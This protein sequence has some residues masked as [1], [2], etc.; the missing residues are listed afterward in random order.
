MMDQ[1]FPELKD[2]NYQEEFLSDWWS[3][4]KLFKGKRQCGKS[5]LIISEL[6]RFEKHSFSAVVIAPTMDQARRL[7]DR[8]HERFGSHARADFLSFHTAVDGVRGMKVDVV[9]IDELQETTFDKVNSIIAYTGPLFVRATACKS[10]FDDH[11]YLKDED[12][13]SGF[14]DSVYSV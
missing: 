1:E 6:N 3:R 2:H 9:L 11:H 4:K 8:Y 5:T 10:R 12:G 7:R 14:F 13:D